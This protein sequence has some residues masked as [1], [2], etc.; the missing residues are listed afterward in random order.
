MLEVCECD[1]KQKGDNAEG[2]QHVEDRYLLQVDEGSDHDSR[3]KKI[4]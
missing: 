1:D 2:R 3:D 4:K